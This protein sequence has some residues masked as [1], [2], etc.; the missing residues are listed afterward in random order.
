MREH[1]AKLKTRTINYEQSNHPPFAVFT[2]L[3]TPFFFAK[4]E[5]RG[6]SHAIVNLKE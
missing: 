2:V 6:F 3:T 4:V 1:H 5:D